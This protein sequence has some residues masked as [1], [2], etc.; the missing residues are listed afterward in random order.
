MQADSILHS[1]YFHPVLRAWQ[2]TATS[3]NA[4]NL[5]YPIF[6]TDAPDAVEPINS[7]PGQASFPAPLCSQG[8]QCAAV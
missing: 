1:G 6:I 3:L 8:L 5:M 7:L 2:S 4:S